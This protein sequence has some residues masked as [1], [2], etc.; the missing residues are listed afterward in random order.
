MDPG[1]GPGGERRPLTSVRHHPPGEPALGW[2]YW[3]FAP[4]TGVLRSVTHRRVEWPPGRPLRAVCLI[5]GHEAPAPGCAC[6]IHAHPDLATLR[7]EGLCLA[8]GQALIAGR[9]RMWGTV[10]E[11]GHGLRA[12]HAYPD[13]LFLVSAGDDPAT[14]A[15]LAR[16]EAFG[17]PVATLAPEEALGDVAAAILRHQAMSR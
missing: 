4:G 9:V 3:Q 1:P 13:A 16:L 10:V 8:P 6:G 11:D 15:V 14:V 12:E 5:G 17:V 7:E 2:R